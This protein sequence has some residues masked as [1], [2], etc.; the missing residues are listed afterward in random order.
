MT[1]FLVQLFSAS[2]MLTIVVAFCGFFAFGCE[3]S[4]FAGFIFVMYL[5][6]LTT[7]LNLLGTCPIRAL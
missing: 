3:Y 6:A 7:F 2:F 4:W 5:L 1:H